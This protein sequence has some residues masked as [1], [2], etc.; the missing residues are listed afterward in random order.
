MAAPG[1][2][3]RPKGFKVHVIIR[4]RGGDFLYGEDEFAVMRSDVAAMKA[5]ADGVVIRLGSTRTAA[6]IKRGAPN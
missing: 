3:R 2:S 1:P 5:G 6:S 4:P